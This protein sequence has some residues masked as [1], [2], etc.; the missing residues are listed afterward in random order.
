M[1]RGKLVSISLIII[2]L[3]AVFVAGY[4]LG[5]VGPGDGLFTTSGKMVWDVTLI[6]IMIYLVLGL[7]GL[8]FSLI[9]LFKKNNYH[10]IAF[11]LLFMSLG[12]LTVVPAG[13][14]SRKVAGIFNYKWTKKYDIDQQI[15]LEEAQ[16]EEKESEIISL[17]YYQRMDKVFKVHYEYFTKLLL[18]PQ[19]LVEQFP[20]NLQFKTQNG[21]M[22][23]VQNTENLKNDSLNKE[24]TLKLPPYEIFE[25]KYS[26]YLDMFYT[27]S[28]VIRKLN[29]LSEEDV[30]KYEDINNEVWGPQKP[31]W[32][33]VNISYP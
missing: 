21:L 25:K 29:F 10:W 1:R 31:N 17:S 16:K 14:V 8:V 15:K 7:L 3:L 33:P 4:M 9:Y 13:Y 18:E 22:V 23:F 20:N 28:S 11:I 24:V 26:D 12:L 5:I 32:I 19:V 30:V 27:G 6:S 2:Q